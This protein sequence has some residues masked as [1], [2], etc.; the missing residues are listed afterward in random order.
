MKSK[1]ST[2]LW[3]LHEGNN[4]GAN[5]ALLEYFE[6]LHDMGYQ[7]RVISP[8]KG[9]FTSLLIDKNINTSI[10]PMYSWTRPLNKGFFIKGWLK[11]NLRNILA[12]IQIAKQ[13]RGVQAVCTNTLCNI[14]GAIAAKLTFKPHYW[15][16]HEFGEEDHGFR[17][18]LSQKK[19]YKLMLGLSKKIVLNSLSVWQKWERVL[20]SERKLCLLYNV[21]NSPVFDLD[22]HETNRHIAKNFLMLGQISRAKGHLLAIETI[23]Q[24]RDEYPEINLDIIGSVTDESYL[25]VLHNKIETNNA[26]HYIKVK[27]PVNN[28]FDI[29]HNYKALLMCSRMEAFGRVTVEAMKA[30]LPVIGFN[31]GGTK[32]IINHNRNG[33]LV[34]VPFKENLGPVI[35]QFIN[36]GDIAYKNMCLEAMQI[37]NK[38]NHANARKQLDTIFNTSNYD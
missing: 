20:G 15:F 26:S 33:A 3:V 25:M 16:V 24:L 5:M 14:S 8:A 18:A 9:T 35:K 23:V 22:K 21:V 30:G 2:L 36:M 12:V 27:P 31:S 32:E 11:R 7:L 28:P 10:V 29:F 13:T 37:K 1:S 34:E 17:L 19:A 6:V 4:S 38:F